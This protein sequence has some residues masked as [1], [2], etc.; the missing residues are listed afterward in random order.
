VR[1]LRAF[2]LLLWLAVPVSGYLF[3]RADYAAY[4]ADSHQ[5]R[6]D[7]LKRADIL[8]RY[9][10]LIATRAALIPDIA[11]SQSRAVWQSR[12]RQLQR[13][14]EDEQRHLRGSPPAHYPTADSQL[15]ALEQ[16]LSSEKTAVDAAVRERDAYNKAGGGLED[17]LAEIQRTQGIAEY[18]RSIGAEGI[19][20]LIRDD[21]RVLESE[22][23]ARTRER[24]ERMQDLNVELKTV[25]DCRDEIQDGLLDIPALIKADEQTT[26]TAELRQRLASFNL[27]TEVT[28]WLGLPVREER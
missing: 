3:G 17:L 26:Y 11:D 9:S 21:A 7:C 8:G 20:E 4:L 1:L 28:R 18:Y 2:I 14:L 27:V 19:Y 16:L 10:R 15:S 24:N 5:Q 13:E 23:R 25:R 6:A 22:Y 12:W